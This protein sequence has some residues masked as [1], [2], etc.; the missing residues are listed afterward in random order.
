[1]R[2]SLLAVCCVGVAAAGCGADRFDAPSGKMCPSDSPAYSAPT[3][4][5]RSRGSPDDQWA[6]LART[7]PGGFG[8]V[9]Y[10]ANH[11][12]TVVLVDPSKKNQAFSALHA[13]GLFVDGAAVAKGRWN[14][15]QLYDW[16]AYI[17][18]R[19]PAVTGLRTVDIDELA[20]RLAFGLADSSSIHAFDSTLARMNLPCFLVNTDIVGNIVPAD[21]RP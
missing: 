4:S 18:D 12:F 13:A 8:G 2:G 9:Y 10:D 7:V 16:L 1:M 20:N 21:R 3:Q 5:Q 17:Q 14:F 19:S 11:T 15:A 6:A